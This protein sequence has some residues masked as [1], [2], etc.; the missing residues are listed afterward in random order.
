MKTE[1]AEIIE[2]GEAQVQQVMSEAQT[3]IDT[4]VEAAQAMA[5]EG[6]NDRED[7]A[8]DKA[9]DELRKK[10]RS[11]GNWTSNNWTLNNGTLNKRVTRFNFRFFNM[12][13]AGVPGF[14]FYKPAGRERTAA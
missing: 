8:K 13:V 5:E 6:V 1:G 9:E 12:L 3:R 11:F 7:Q 4:A 14:T 2:Q 10:L